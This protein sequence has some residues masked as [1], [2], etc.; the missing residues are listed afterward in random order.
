MEWDGMTNRSATWKWSVCGLLLLATMLNYMDRQT[1]AQTATDIRLE[2]SLSKA[3]YGKLEMGF[4]F[5]FALGGLTIGLLC[6]RVSVFFMY[7]LVL[8]AWSLAGFSTAYAYE[9]GGLLGGQTTSERAFR[10]FMFCRIV[11]GYFEAGQWP[12]ALITTS[13]LLSRKERSLGNSI[14][15]SGAAIGAIL[16]PLVI[17][18]MSTSFWWGP[19]QATAWVGNGAADSTMTIPFAYQITG[20]SSPGTWRLPF[21]V[22]GLIGMVWVIPWFLMIR[23]RHLAADS[24][25]AADT[26]EPQPT[27]PADVLRSRF[28]ACLVTVISINLTWQFLRAWLPMFL[29]EFHHYDAATVNYFTSCYYVSTDVGCIASGIFGR[30]LV[31][32]GWDVHGARYTTFSICAAITALAVPVAFMPAGPMLLGLLLVIGASALGLFPNY[33]AFSQD[34]SHRNQGKVT[35]SLGAITW[36]A[37]SI[38]QWLIGERIEATQSFRVGIIMAGVAPLCAVVALWFL[39][40]PAPTQ[41]PEASPTMSDEHAAAVRS[42]S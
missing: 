11:L 9:I 34:L 41:Q 5:A 20:V 38:M 17:Q 1:L 27:L 18:G 12:C 32:R 4:G 8:I 35:G 33:Y 42:A 30:W 15:Q 10:G 36:V 14:L 6:D 28:L 3:D 23:P 24:P 31:T 19:A 13:R 29:R 40:K 26:A 7:P 37:S 39:W 2:L 25:H 21:K 16:T 22:I